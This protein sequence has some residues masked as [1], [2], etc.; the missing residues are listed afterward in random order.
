[1]AETLRLAHRGDWRAA[2]ENSL[3]ALQAALRVPGC[4]GL[5]FDVRASSDG[6]PI[7][8]HD[9]SLRRVQKVNA[10]PSALTAAECARHGI[11]SL[12]EVLR[13]VG[14]DAFLDVELKELVPAVIDVLELERGRTGDDGQS[15]LGAA[16]VS[17]F[18]E[19]VLEWLAAERPSWPRWLNARDLSPRTIDLAR[20]LGCTAI[21]VW[22]RA[23]GP[24]RVE[25]ARDA[26][27]D[28][29]A[30]TVTDPAAYRRIEALGA[31]AICAEGAAL[32]G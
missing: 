25:R 20:R 27:L 12:G 19:A 22:W 14:C 30:W 17:S 1:V 10:V 15:V 13:E 29:A 4:D 5:E 23:I 16:A 7:L 21:S 28:I 31:I 2:P 24:G 26:G 3:E 9:A 18:E 8:L 11:S 6:V 32:D